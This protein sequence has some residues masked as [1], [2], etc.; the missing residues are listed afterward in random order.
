MADEAIETCRLKKTLKSNT[1]N[2]LLNLNQYYSLKKNYPK[3]AWRTLELLLQKYIILNQ[4]K[5][6]WKKL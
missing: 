1:Y 6:P 5:L 2:T 4:M 3:Q